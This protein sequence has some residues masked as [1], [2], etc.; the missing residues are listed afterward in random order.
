MLFLVP[1]LSVQFAQ[2]QD[3]SR[4]GLCIENDL[5]RAFQA[6]RRGRFRP[7]APWLTDDGQDSG[8]EQ[9][10]NASQEQDSNA[11][12]DGTNQDCTDTHEAFGIDISH[13]SVDPNTLTVEQ[14]HVDAWIEAGVQHA[15]VGTQ[16]EDRTQQQLG[17]LNEN[18]I[19]TDAYVW[20][21]WNTASHGTMEEQ[22]QQALDIVDGYDVGR[23]WLDVE[24]TPD[25]QTA[26]DLEGL[27]QDA[28]DAF[29]EEVR[30]RGLDMDVG[31][32]SGY[33]FWTSYMGNTEAFSDLPLWY[34]HYDN[35]PSFD[36]W[37]DLNFG[38][39]EEPWGKQYQGT[40]NL[41]DASPVVDL[42]TF[43]LPDCD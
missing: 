26:S 30:E 43:N 4:P 27:V 35:D 32:Y 9:D 1:L 5:R 34:A 8:Q 21:H 36:D 17:I 18:G 25:G 10:S 6:G 37:E 13:W 16:R 38:G 29:N 19:S 15:I 39:W 22:I 31:I 24:E 20:L 23:L 3:C 40:S 7:P 33:G 41:N 12:Q 2:A 14:E 28:I 11:S 42:N